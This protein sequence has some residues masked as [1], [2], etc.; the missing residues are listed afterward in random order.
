MKTWMLLAP[1]ALLVTVPHAQQ[2]KA[3]VGI[4]NV[5]L[6]VQAMP[7]GANYVA[8]SKK[9]DTDLQARTQKVQE[10]AA[11]LRSGKATAADR[12][13][14][15]DAQKAYTTTAQSYSKQLSTA[16]TPLASKVNAAVAAVAKSS[17]YSVVLD[18]RVALTNGLVVYANE[19][20]TDLTAAVKARVVSGK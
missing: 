4:V 5:Q 3:R 6:V 19:Q 9:A 10:L 13:A 1:L 14:Y 16:F 17:G 20:A 12:T 15:V 2:A 11:R 8:L 7:G 18:R